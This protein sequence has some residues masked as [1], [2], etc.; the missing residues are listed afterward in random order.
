MQ[1][2]LAVAQLG[3]GGA[4]VFDQRIAIHGLAGQWLALPR[5]AKVTPKQAPMPLPPNSTS[6]SASRGCVG[7]IT[8]PSNAA[9]ALARTATNRK[10]V[11]WRRNKR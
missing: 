7:L 4:Q 9:K 10:A 1:Q 3:D 11:D 2:R 5:L 6:T 8:Q